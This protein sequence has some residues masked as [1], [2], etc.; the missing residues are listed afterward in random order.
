M[1]F[2]VKRFYTRQCLALAGRS[3]FYYNL[4]TSL[5]SGYPILATGGV[6]SADVAL[7]FLHVNI[8]SNFEVL[9]KV[10]NRLDQKMTF[11]YIILVFDHVKKGLD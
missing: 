10:L 7:Q 2:Q 3:S 1:L 6:D 4:Q 9:F 8:Y 5:L 11:H